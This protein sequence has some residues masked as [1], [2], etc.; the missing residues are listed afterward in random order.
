MGDRGAS[1]PTPFPKL[2]ALSMELPN[3]FC[4]D[5]YVCILSMYKCFMEELVRGTKIATG[6]RRNWSIC[7]HVSLRLLLPFKGAVFLLSMVIYTLKIRKREVR[8]QFQ[9]G[10]QLWG[11]ESGFRV[12]SVFL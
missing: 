1:H 4:S 12:C 3:S 5:L 7:G 6:V 8:S 9:T 2:L 10:W 11:A